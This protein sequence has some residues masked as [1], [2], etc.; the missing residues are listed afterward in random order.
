MGG[1][2][3]LTCF[4]DSRPI[5]VSSDFTIMCERNY[6]LSL[7]LDE[8][9]NRFYPLADPNAAENSVYGILALTDRPYS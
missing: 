4:P 2:R 8:I 3:N 9:A 5:N 6:T 7:K 1:E